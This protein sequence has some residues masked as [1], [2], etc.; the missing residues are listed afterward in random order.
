[1]WL[2]LW[3]WFYLQD[4]LASEL[5]EQQQR[6]RRAGTDGPK[7]SLRESEER[8]VRDERLREDL[9]RS[10][11]QRLDL[12]AALLDRDSRAMEIKFDLEAKVR[13]RVR[14]GRVVAGW[15]TD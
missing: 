6:A 4:E 9:E 2:W 7:A 15:C 8:F 14:G 11:K 13:V 10:R 5:E 12:E 1:M 3:L